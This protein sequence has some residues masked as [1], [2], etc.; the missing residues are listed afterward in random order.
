[1]VPTL[2]WYF[3]FLLLLLLL[4]SPLFLLQLVHPPVSVAVGLQADLF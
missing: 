3:F 1:L 4:L 2:C